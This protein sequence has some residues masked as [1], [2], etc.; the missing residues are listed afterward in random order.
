MTKDQWIAL[1]GVVATLLGIVVTWLVAGRT[2]AKKQLSYRMSLDSLM[3]KKLADPEEK[4][5]IKYK[6]ELLVEPVLLSVDI[7]NTGNA[8]I[9]NPPIEV[10]A[11]GATYVIPGYFE[12]SP[13][14]YEDLWTIERTDAES[15][16][17]RLAHIN[18]GQTVRARLLL[19]EFPD[20]RPVF[21]CPMMGVEVKELARVEVSSFTQAVL[22]I[23][24]PA[25]SQAIKT[26][27]V[28]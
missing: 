17:I 11:V 21:K 9:E 6:G 2:Q 14:G 4:L 23:L 16:A 25:V 22:E 7:T 19:D 1:G 13:A 12:G 5:E 28:R 8:P 27:N 20:D 24:V 3:P 10:E 18:P 26:V 15:C